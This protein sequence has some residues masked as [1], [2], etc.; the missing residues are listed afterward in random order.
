MELFTNALIITIG[1]MAG[2][3]VFG[4]AINLLRTTLR[5]AQRAVDNAAKERDRQAYIARA[6]ERRDK[7]E[8]TAQHM[9]ADNADL[10][11]LVADIRNAPYVDGKTRAARINNANRARL[12]KRLRE[13]VP[14]K[15]LRDIFYGS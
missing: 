12:Q 5:V 8:T 11:D 9:L 1:I 4:L 2:L 6:K 14:N 7:L 13:M 3:F 15:G 10:A